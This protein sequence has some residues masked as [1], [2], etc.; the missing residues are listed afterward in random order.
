MVKAGR[1][2]KD[3]R[4]YGFGDVRQLV[5]LDANMTADIRLSQPLAIAPQG[6][7]FT[8]NAVQVENLTLHVLPIP[9][10]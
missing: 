9:L 8:I 6:T 1:T 5:S 4:D 7:D 10:V 2:A 3:F